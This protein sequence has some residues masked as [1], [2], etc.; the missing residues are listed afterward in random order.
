[1]FALT[2]HPNTHPHAAGLASIN[3]TFGVYTYVDPPAY[4]IKSHQSALIIC[5]WGKNSSHHSNQCQPMEALGLD[6]IQLHSVNI[7][8]NHSNRLQGSGSNVLFLT[9]E[10]SRVCK[11]HTRS[12]FTGFHWS[13]GNKARMHN[14]VPQLSPCRPE[15]Q[16]AK[17]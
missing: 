3:L 13:C 6:P 5:T 1:M 9:V 17:K 15:H 16:T 4:P 8:N 11:K 7:E 10:Y 14:L 2:V 12:E